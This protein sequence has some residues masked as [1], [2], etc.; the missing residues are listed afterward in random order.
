M[1]Q[2]L[3]HVLHHQFHRLTQPPEQVAETRALAFQ[4]AQFFPYV[5][6]H[7]FF[8]LG[9]ALVVR[10]GLYAALLL[11]V[12]QEMFQHIVDKG[13]RFRSVKACSL[14][15]FGFQAV[16]HE[17][18][19][20][21]ALDGVHL[22]RRQAHLVSVQGVHGAAAQAAT[23]VLPCQP[24]PSGAEV[25]LRFLF[26]GVQEGIIPV[27]SRPLQGR[28]GRHGTGVAVRMSDGQFWQ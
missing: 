6:L 12:P 2:L 15:C 13:A 24:H 23:G 25:P 3:H 1:F 11:G 19:E 7:H 17:V 26:Q 5:L 22:G 21:T 16:L 14:S 20:V 4:V 9:F 27:P 10:H 18:G 8:H 28:Q